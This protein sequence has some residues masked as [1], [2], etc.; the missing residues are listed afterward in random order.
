[1]LLME[2]RLPLVLFAACGNCAEPQRR[3]PKRVSCI[4]PSASPTRGRVL[5]PDPPPAQTEIQPHLFLAG[6]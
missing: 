5:S 1:M 2:I 6:A 4:I 3:E